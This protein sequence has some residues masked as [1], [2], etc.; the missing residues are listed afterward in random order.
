[1]DLGEP[2]CAP[3]GASQ[4]AA[5]PSAATEG[6]VQE[7]RGSVAFEHS[8]DAADG[9]LMSQP[10][11]GVPDPSRGF[12][13]SLVAKL[14]AGPSA[15]GEPDGRAALADATTTPAL[16]MPVGLF[17]RHYGG[18]AERNLDA[19]DAATVR[20]NSLSVPQE[21]LQ[22]WR[23]RWESKHL[24]AA[25]FGASAA[26]IMAQPAAGD[27]FGPHRL[28][29]VSPKTLRTIHSLLGEGLLQPHAPPTYGRRM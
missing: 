21:K 12:F 13:S 7:P 11:P 14:V 25:G 29:N 5:A 9:S 15:E 23:A 26:S 20:S 1:M 17:D 18:A 19:S 4:P 16:T 3:A 2:L 10:S 6:H 8:S 28:G 24:D 27:L 22:T